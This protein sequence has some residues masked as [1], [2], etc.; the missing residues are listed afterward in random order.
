[1]FAT[2]Y[3]IEQNPLQIEHKPRQDIL[4]RERRRLVRGSRRPA[5][6]VDLDRAVERIDQPAQMCSLRRDTRASSS[7]LSSCD[8]TRD[9]S[10]ITKSGQIG[11]ELSPR[12]SASVRAFRRSLEIQRSIRRT[13]CPVGERETRPM[14]RRRCPVPSI[15]R[16]ER[17]A[18]AVR[19]GVS[20]TRG[21]A[22]RAA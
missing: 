10:S 12:C 13:D 17:R 18:W 7:E 14:N 15:V 19:S 5:G 11:A 8:L 20:R 21:P 9:R 3:S 2:S 6:P 22:G 16:P 4:A 1:M